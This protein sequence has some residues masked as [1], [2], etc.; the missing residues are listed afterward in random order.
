VT[1]RPALRISVIIPVF[2]GAA[3]L[4]LC[5]QAL[6]DSKY[7]PAEC[8]VVDD[9]STDG[10][11]SIAERMGATVLFTGGRRGP[12]TARNV[13]AHHATGDLLLFLDAD[14]AIHADAVGRIVERF[15]AEPTLD[16][17]IG[18]Y[19]DAPLCSRFV[20][21]FKNLM[22]SFVHHHGNPRAFSFWCGC[23]AV[24][25]AV[26]L[27]QGGLNESYR[28]PSIE[29]IEFGFR[30]LRAGRKLALD[31]K[32]QCKHLKSW[33]LWNLMRTD[34]LQ[35]GIPWTELILRT[36][37]LP[38]D[39]NLRW[40]QRFSVILSA[41]LVLLAGLEVWQTLA[42]RG[43]VP[44]SMAA[45]G[46]FLSLAAI[47]FLNRSFYQFLAS[48]KGWR[49]SLFAVWLHIFYYVYSGVSFALGA[50]SYGFR[51]VQPDSPEEAAA[52]RISRNQS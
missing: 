11:A 2:D 26:F 45:A 29:D 50:G 7:P 33:T 37:F 23:G 32:V 9:G 42:G 44:V 3:T 48:R 38:D 18:S 30:M 20:S 6:L 35:R 5:L 47:Y 8:V 49:F 36:R 51:A 10:S 34:V 12:A 15:E 40:S 24:K 31:P 25:R 4:P 13:G 28:R 19:D 22:H 17:L 41:L 39:L 21:Q 46:I 43:L 1:T 27:E 14:V 16:A 52:Q